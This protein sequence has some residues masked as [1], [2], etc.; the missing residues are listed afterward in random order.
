M[1]LSIVG[2]D[3]NLRIK[4]PKLGF[5]RFFSKTFANLFFSANFKLNFLQFVL[6]TLCDK[7]LYF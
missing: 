5:F 6:Q 1:Q 4:G 2:S 7:K 3:L